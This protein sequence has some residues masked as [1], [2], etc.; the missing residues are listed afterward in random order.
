MLELLGTYPAFFTFDASST[1]SAPLPPNTLRGQKCRQPRW[2]DE[3]NHFLKDFQQ[4][5]ARS[6]H[7][8]S[9][10]HLLSSFV[11]NEVIETDVI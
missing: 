3:W 2:L 10:V 7:E 9:G 11:E 1:L 6:V 8:I 4:L 5:G